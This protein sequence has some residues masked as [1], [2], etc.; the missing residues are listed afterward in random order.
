MNDFYSE[1]EEPIRDLVKYLR[2]NGINTTNSCGHQMTIQCDV[3]LSGWLQLLHNLLF[4]YLSDHKIE[5]NYTIEVRVE[6]CNGR[7]WR[8]WADIKI[9]KDSHD[10]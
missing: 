10:I 5:P 4:N 3:V 6:V 7:L 1:I 8:E 9:M 2:D